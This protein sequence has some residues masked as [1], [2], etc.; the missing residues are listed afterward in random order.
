MSRRRNKQQGAKMSF[1][2]DDHSATWKIK[3]KFLR[4]T[5]SIHPPLLIELSDSMQPAPDNIV[6]SIGSDAIFSTQTNEM[7]SATFF[8]GVVGFCGRLQILR[9]RLT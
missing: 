8:C 7:I 1:Q 6:G 4:P 3:S 2:H 5:P 9:Q